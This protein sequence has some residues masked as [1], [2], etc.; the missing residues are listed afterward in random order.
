MKIKDTVAFILLGLIWGQTFLWIKIGVAALPPVVFV[1]LRMIFA[2]IFLGAVVLISK[3]ARP[4]SRREW[5]TLVVLGIINMA[6]PFL[7]VAWGE[8]HIDSA[9]AAILH[10]TVPMFTMLIAHV[11]LTD[12]RMDVMRVSGLIVGFIGIILILFQ[13]LGGADFRSNLLGQGAILL[14]SLSYAVSSVVARYNAKAVSPI[15]QAFIPLVVADV[16]TWSLALGSS[17]PMELPHTGLAWF[18]IL[19]LGIVASGIGYLIYFYLI[20]SI[21]PTRTTLVTYIFPVLGVVLGVVFLNEKLVWNTVVGGLIVIAGI[22]IVNLRR[23]EVVKLPQPD[24][25][26]S[27]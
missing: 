8:Q 14:A 19:Y 9:I 1:S 27:K 18:A 4:T 22:A 21:G 23:P 6:F 16:F 12:D 7:L 5:I 13:D 26:I 24:V 11:V 3:P 15:Y 2:I 10:S 20:Q 17:T 25:G